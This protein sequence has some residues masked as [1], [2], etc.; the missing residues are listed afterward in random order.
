MVKFAEVKAVPET[1]VPVI[2]IVGATVYP[3]PLLVTR[4]KAVG[5]AKPTVGATV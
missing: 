3:E 5:P 2:V 4:F 1:G